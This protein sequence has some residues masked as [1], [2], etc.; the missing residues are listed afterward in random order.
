MVKAA[1][2]SPEPAEPPIRLSAAEH[3]VPP[4]SV[5]DLRFGERER[6]AKEGVWREI[7]R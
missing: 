7:G 4:A 3:V 6:S 1:R 5:Y 2:R